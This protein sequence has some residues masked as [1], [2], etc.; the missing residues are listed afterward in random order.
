MAKRLTP[1]FLLQATRLPLADRI[2]LMDALRRSVMETT[3][4]EKRLTY[5]ADKML[6]ITGT[7]VREDTRERSV[8]TARFIFMFYR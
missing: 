8:A 4:T 7:D 2:A 3:S 6:E 5:L 1:T